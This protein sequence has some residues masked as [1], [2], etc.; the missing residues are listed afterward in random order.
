MISDDSSFESLEHVIVGLWLT[1]T[2][3]IGIWAHPT[4]ANT[5]SS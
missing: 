1:V 2:L 3:G 5:K 4:F